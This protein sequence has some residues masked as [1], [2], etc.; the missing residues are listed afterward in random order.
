MQP[1][2]VDEPALTYFTVEQIAA[3]DPQNIP[4]HVAIVLDGNRRWA[5]SQGEDHAH[6]HRKGADVLLDI[7]RSAKEIGIKTVTVYGFSTENWNRPPDEVQAVLWLIEQYCIEQLPQ[8]LA[9]GV[10]VRVIGN[11]AGLPDTLKTVLENTRQA[12]AHCTDVEM[13]MA[14]NY[15]GRNEICRAVN[16]IFE[17]IRSGTVRDEPITEELISHF[18]DTQDLPDPELWIRPGG[19]LR[20]SNFLLWQSTYAELY[21]LDKMWPE[22]TPQDLLQAVLTYQQRQRR[23]GR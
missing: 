8:M 15:G 11:M 13:V 12:T 17:A 20:I 5:E 23:M 22:F 3:L 10:K 6:G 7:V 2:F 16:T 21:F 18:L 4:Q 9:N 19:E 14:L 1:L